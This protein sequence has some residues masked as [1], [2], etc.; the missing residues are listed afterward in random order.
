MFIGRVR[1][2]VVATQKLD[3]MA[4]RKLLIVEPL[5]VAED[6]EDFKSTGLSYVA[7]DDIDAG[8]DDLVL[9]TQGSSS[10]MTARTSD[11]PVDC[12]VIGIIDTVTLDGK[13]F[14]SKSAG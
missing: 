10:R 7:V 11:A 13:P 5:V 3:K 6:G 9:V 2:N 4:A 8:T 12:I 14:Y 1:G